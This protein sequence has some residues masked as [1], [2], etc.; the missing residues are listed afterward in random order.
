MKIIADTHTHTISSTHAFSTIEEMIAA[1]ARK[2]LYAIALTDHGYAM[3]G[4]PGKWFF[5]SLGAIPSTY[6]GVRVLKGVEAN[7]INLDGELDMSDR[8]LS[9]LEWVVA[10]IHGALCKGKATVESCTNAYLRLAENPYVKVIGHS[11]TPQY[12]YDYERVIPVFAEKGKLVEINNNTFYS[13]KASCA[14]CME[15]AKICKKVGAPVVVNSDAH[16]SARVGVCD[17]AFAM[18]REIDFPEELVI[19]SSESRFKKYLKENGISTC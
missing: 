16:F 5:E 10:S 18:L 7:V 4:A 14:N 2:R 3:P 9:G 12:K 19:N 11:G 1:A 8:V 13:R 6:N 15:I 17:E